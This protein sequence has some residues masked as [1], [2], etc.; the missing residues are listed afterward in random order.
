MQITGKLSSVCYGKK[1]LVFLHKLNPNQDWK[2][3][4]KFPRAMFNQL[5][6]KQNLSNCGTQ[7]TTKN[8]DTQT[9]THIQIHALFNTLIP[10]ASVSSVL[11]DYWFRTWFL[12]VLAI[13]FSSHRRTFKDITIVPKWPQ[14]PI[15]EREREREREKGSWGG[16]S[17][18]FSCNVSK[19]LASTRAEFFREQT[20]KCILLNEATVHCPNPYYQLY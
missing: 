12:W 5:A 3:E 4:E 6:R 16:G 18:F 17:L 10:N 1:R 7:I 9:R 19:S 14:P 15:K 8:T 20:V 2:M 13:L 11:C